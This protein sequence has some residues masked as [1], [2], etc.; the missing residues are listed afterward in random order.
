MTAFEDSMRVNF[1][2][3][4]PSVTTR[5]TVAAFCHA[6]IGLVVFD[7]VSVT[8]SSPTYPRSSNP[9]VTDVV[10]T[11]AA[12][13]VAPTITTPVTATR[14]L[15]AVSVMVLPLSGV[16]VTARDRPGVGWNCR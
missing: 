12:A 4:S 3:Y 9:V 16:D 5:R 14:T 11:G 8:P 6:L 2:V 10:R 1:R 13:V 15:A 7:G